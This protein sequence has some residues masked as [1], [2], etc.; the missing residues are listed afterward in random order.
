MTDTARTPPT[1]FTL[2]CLTGVATLSLNM[3]VPSLV[4]IAADFDASYQLVSLSIAGYMAVTALLQVVIGPLSDRYG[5]RPVMLWSLV[6]FTLASLGCLLA[7]DIRTFLGFRLLQG[8]I[9]AGGALSRVVV[10]DML[11]PKAATSRLGYISM[12][13]AVAPMLGP[14][15]GGLLD[16]AFGWRA[17]FMA[18]SLIGFALWALTWADMGETNKAPSATFGAQFRAYP[19]LLLSPVFWAY[20]VSMAFSVGAFYVFIVG[21]PLVAATLF[22]ISPGR[23]GI[24]M[25]TITGGYMLGSFVAARFGRHFAMETQVLAG[26]MIA[27][28][29]LLCGLC[30]FGLGF[31]HELTLFGATIF[32][33][34]GNGITM[35]AASVG[36][37]SVRADLAGTAAGLSGA[38]LVGV[39]AVLSYI[40]SVVLASGGGNNGAA[41]LGIMLAVTLVGLLG[42]VCVRRTGAS[43]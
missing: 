7:A 32:V 14:A 31:G 16:E 5:R 12:V 25:G 26:R 18:F 42:A 19:T 20:S 11:P 33:G 43:G 30:L 22:E 41:L 23:L 3:F 24:Y 10:R 34:I 1:I 39:G 29:G 9:I 6:L 8:A 35:P 38:L 17:S 27:A 36:V 2:I 28:F 21:V 37:M 40:A 13:M 15:M 4:N